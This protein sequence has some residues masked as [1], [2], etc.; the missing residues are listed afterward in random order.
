MS[1]VFFST[2]NLPQGT[3]ILSPLL[4]SKTP[5]C[6]ASRSEFFHQSPTPLFQIL[7]DHPPLLTSRM[8]Y[9]VVSSVVCTCTLICT[10]Q[11]CVQIGLGCSETNLHMSAPH[12]LE[13]TKLGSNPGQ[14]SEEC[15]SYL[16]K[17]AIRTQVRLVA[18]FDNST[19]CEDERS[20]TNSR[21]PR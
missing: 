20:C 12:Q 1:L 15:N 18:L 19:K 9:E 13:A 5:S 7:T 2:L 14:E 11:D 3:Q 8:R 16:W 6:C 10:P 21:I 17:E 4:A